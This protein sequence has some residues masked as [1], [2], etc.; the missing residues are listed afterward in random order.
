MKKLMAV[1]VVVVAGLGWTMA[2]AHAQLPGGG[3]GPQGGGGR[4]GIGRLGGGPGGPGGAGRGAGPGI[5]LAAL[6]LSDDQQTQVKALFESERAT[7][8]ANA[9]AVMEARAAL[10]AAVFAP[11]VDSNALTGLQAKVSAAEQAQLA[12]EVQ[13]ELTLAGILTPEQ[14]AKVASHRGPGRNGGP[15]RQR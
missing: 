6:N 9:L 2:V 10:R 5:N 1:A 14:R 11:T 3:P 8:Q 7:N 13:S 15:R 12:S 4:Q